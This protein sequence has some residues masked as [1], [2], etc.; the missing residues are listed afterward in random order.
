MPRATI[1]ANPDYRLRPHHFLEIS[2]AGARL[3][4]SVFSASHETRAYERAIEIALIL[5]TAGIWTLICFAIHLL[6]AH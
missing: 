4:N 6:N 2:Q 5:L 1:G 3:D